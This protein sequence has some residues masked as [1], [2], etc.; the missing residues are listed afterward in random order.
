MSAYKEFSTNALFIAV[1]EVVVRALPA[2]LAVCNRL[3]VF[4]NNS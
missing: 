4:E 2:L 3:F 1:S